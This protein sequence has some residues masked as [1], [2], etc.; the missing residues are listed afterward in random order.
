MASRA[1][2]KTAAMAIQ[3]FGYASQTMQPATT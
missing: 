2:A 3:A 1:L